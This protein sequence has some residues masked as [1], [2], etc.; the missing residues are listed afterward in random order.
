MLKAVLF[1]LDGVI[2]DTEP[3]YARN[4]L[5]MAQRMN[6]PLT[7]EFQKNYVGVSHRVL[8]ARLKELYDIPYTVDEL[9][10]IEREFMVN[11]FTSGELIPINGTIKLIKFLYENSIKCAIVTSNVEKNVQIIIKR[12]GIEKCISSVASADKVK[13]IKPAPDLFLF[14]C[15]ELT[16]PP[17]NCIAIDDCEI[18]ITGAKSAN[19]KAVGFI[20]PN[21]GKQDFSRADY[22]VDDMSKLSV[23]ILLKLLF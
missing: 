23:D 8:W 13:M 4:E 14:A 20:N 2:V 11:Y 22:I 10:L 1:D 7:K 15:N 16:I 18:G 5:E 12:L 9:S 17:E 19:M 3:V 21:S 6:L